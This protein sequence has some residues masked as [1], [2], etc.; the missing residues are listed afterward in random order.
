MVSK[1]LLEH[2]GCSDKRLREIFTAQVAPETP[3]AVSLDRINPPRK[4]KSDSEIRQ[5]FEARIRSRLIDGIGIGLQNSRAFQ[6]VDMA[7]DGQPIFPETIP[8]MLWARGKIKLEQLEQACVKA[9]TPGPTA[10]TFFKKNE[11]N[12][13]TGMNVGRISEI[14]ID[15]VKSYTRRRL[16]AMNSLW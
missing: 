4:P 16:A 7:C 11:R 5:R 13:I 12:E 6:A 2:Y 10:Q 3:A 9:G 14:H 15:I 8:L 1:K